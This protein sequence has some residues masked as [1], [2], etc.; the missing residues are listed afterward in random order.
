MIIKKKTKTRMLIK[1]I[2]YINEYDNETYK[3]MK[4]SGLIKIIH[5]ILYNGLKGIIQKT[6]TLYIFKDNVI[7]DY[8]QFTKRCYGY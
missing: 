8:K 2:T 6:K 3:Q 1:E 4:E 7:S 5:I